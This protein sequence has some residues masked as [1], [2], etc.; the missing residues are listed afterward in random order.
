MKSIFSL[1][2]VLL[3]FSLVLYFSGIAV[4]Q[5]PIVEKG[6]LDLRDIKPGSEFSVRMNGE[7]EFWFREFLDPA[8]TTPSACPGPDLYARVP[9]YWT[10]YEIDGHRLPGFGY[11]TYKCIILLPQGFRERLAF[12]MPVF[13][14][15]YELFIN[16]ASIASNGTPGRTRAESVPSYE[17]SFHVYMPKSD[18]LEVILHVSNF[19][20]RKGG[21]WLPVKTGTF[22]KI[23]THY[24]NQLFKAIA[25]V[26]MLFASFL[27]FLLFALF[28]NRNMKL[29]MF[30]VLT[31]GLSLRPFFTS[32]ILITN[33]GITDWNIIVKAEYIT[34][35]LMLAAGTRLVYF[36]Y[37]SQLI[38]YF[39]FA[40]DIL[41]VLSSLMVLGA[42]VYIVSYSDIIIHSIALAIVTYAVIMSLRGAF[43]KRWIDII[44]FSALCAM[45]TGIVIDILIT[46]G[47]GTHDKTYILSSLMIV[48]VFI[49]S[50]LLIRE[51]V[52]SVHEKQ[53]LHQQV[54]DM[55]RNLEKRVVERTSEL[56]EKSDELKAQS[57]RIAQ[58]NRKLSETISLKN[59]IFSVISHDLR[60]PVVN[61]LYTLNMMKEEEFRDKTETLTNSC[62]QY[63]QMVINL[64][65]NMLVWGRGQEEMI[66]YAPA[67]Y[68]LADVILT[69]M[70]IAKETA[71][72]KKISLNFTQVGHSRGWFDRDLVDIIIRNLLS[73]A[74]KYTHHGGR[75]TIHVKERRENGE[76]MIIRVTDNGVGICDERQKKLFTGAEIDTT[77][78][79]DREKGTG[80]GLRLV[81]E[82]VT[83]SMGTITVE[84]TPGHGTC[85]IVSLPGRNGKPHLKR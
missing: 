20:H 60:S 66:R 31:L 14:T 16:G 17:P 82:L 35:F 10:S 50:S 39:A 23:Q 21:F 32:T 4:A 75:V 11:A 73:N 53:R 67:E 33:L 15:S 77:P 9:S 71:D 58:Q 84:S 49:Q 2:L 45:G 80:L 7:W 19:Y 24:A 22:H 30:S 25:V 36:I 83:I 43:R 76:G 85:F 59:K 26:S 42:P 44:Y 63:S 54:E 6:V 81:H 79:T 65:E 70:S 74:I 1:R 48:F 12:D 56:Q 57:N 68:D 34:L 37:P 3:S 46:Q 51:W 27:F 55:N 40:V 61:I 38:R 62:I 64:L 29:L 52:K 41:F 47:R 28:D 13:D 72:R 18:T 5:H 8:V 78:G 69:N